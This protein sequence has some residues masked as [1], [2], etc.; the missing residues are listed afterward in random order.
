MPSALEET[1]R[2][3][4]GHQAHPH[5]QQAESWGGVAPDVGPPLPASGRP[6]A[7]EDHRGA[8]DRRVSHLARTAFHVP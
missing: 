6:A 8:A 3:L 4:S 1:L 5:V 7:A 2:L